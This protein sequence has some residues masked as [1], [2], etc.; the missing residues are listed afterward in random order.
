MITCPNCDH[1]NPEGATQC[2]ACY[3]P[4]PQTTSC[5]NCGA[6]VQTDATFCGQCGQSLEPTAA[7]GGDIPD[8]L[9]ATVVSTGSPAASG[10]SE[11]VST[12]AVTSGESE[13]ISTPVVA[14]SESQEETEVEV[15][16]EVE[17]EAS[18]PPVSMPPTPVI[19]P[20]DPSTLP[21][22]SP[23]PGNSSTQLQVE[24]ASLFHI[25]T[26]TQIELPQNLDVIHLGKPNDK[27]P[28]DIDVSG[29]PDSSIVSRI[30]ADI[31]VEGDTYFLEDVGSANGTYVNHTP[32]SS[33]NRH[34]L[35]PGDRIALGKGDKVTFIFQMS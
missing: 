30:H 22:V 5:P 4:L 8:P 9:P 25:Q 1:Q 31:R 2:E 10:E 13:P 15:E 32:L 19:P 27:I 29:F 6:T 28:P 33:G 7:T 20:P 21:P 24:T 34:R 3:T 16:V 11:P 12:P 14:S 23:L 17:V 18:T 35:R 26:D